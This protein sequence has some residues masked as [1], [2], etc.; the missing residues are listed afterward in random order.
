MGRNPTNFLVGYAYISR[1]RATLR[2]RGSALLTAVII[3]MVLLSISGI[4]FTTVIYQAKN[5]ASEEKALKAYYM[6]EAGIN[7]GAAEVL[8]HPTVY[9]QPELTA[10]LHGPKVPLA[11]GYGGLF[12][13]TIVTDTSVSPNTF[14]VTSTGYYPDRSGVR[15][16]M[17]AQYTFPQ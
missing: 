8:N 9:F 11:N 17:K 10:P 12:D 1:R 15:R 4:F 5:E 16:I 3:V 7:Y 13:V 14:I 6:A 2:E